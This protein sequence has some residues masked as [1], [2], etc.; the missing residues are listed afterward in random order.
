MSRFF[1]PAARAGCEPRVARGWRWRASEPGCRE[2][3]CG[4]IPAELASRTR[5]SPR[6]PLSLALGLRRRRRVSRARGRS[7]PPCR[8]SGR[9][10]SARDL[11]Q[12]QR[13]R[14]RP[15]AEHEVVPVENGRLAGRDRLQ[16][17]VEAHAHAVVAERLDGAGHVRRAVADLDRRPDRP[18]RWR[19]RD[20]VELGGLEAAA[21]QLALRPDHDRVASRVDLDHVERLSRRDAEAAPLPDRVMHD[22]A[23]PAD[24]TSRAIEDRARA[25]LA[26]VLLDEAGV[27]VV[28]HEADLLTL[29]LVG[30]EQAERARPLAHFGLGQPLEWEAAAAEQ[31]LSQRVEDVALVLARVAAARERPATG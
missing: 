28:G 23:V 7:R 1:A 5:R 31:L 4:S 2:E 24:L 16:R 8:W 25:R 19:D 18:P 22:A 6:R 30:R 15:A 12:P 9:A 14:D 26:D 13:P 10:D 3:R 20:P 27:V 11:V 17:R 29:R 21:L